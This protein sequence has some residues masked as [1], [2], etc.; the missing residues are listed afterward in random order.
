VIIYLI[1]R[2]NRPGRSEPAADV[3][4]D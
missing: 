2:R 4:P 1:V 3:V